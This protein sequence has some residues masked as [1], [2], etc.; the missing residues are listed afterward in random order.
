MWLRQA[1]AIRET[2]LKCDSMNR[3]GQVGADPAWFGGMPGGRSRS[4]NAVEQG[5]RAQPI[6][7][8]KVHGKGFYSAPTSGWGATA[9]NIAARAWEFG[10]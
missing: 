4:T 2:A 1:S 9:P 3:K 10:Q 5:E 7:V 6:E 8:I